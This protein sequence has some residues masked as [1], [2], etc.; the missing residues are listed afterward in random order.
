M[1]TTPDTV[2]NFIEEIEA[3]FV[4]VGTNAMRV[5]RGK[6]PLGSIS[7]QICVQAP[8]NIVVSNYTESRRHS[9]S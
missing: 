4:L 8:C 5:D 6:P 9:I 2:V 1:G 7:L 3:D